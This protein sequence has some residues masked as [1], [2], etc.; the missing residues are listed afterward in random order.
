MD[1][2]I[3]AI[4]LRQLK[5]QYRQKY[6]KPNKPV[7]RNEDSEE[8]KDTNLANQSTRINIYKQVSESDGSLVS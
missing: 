2:T 7:A 8:M 1:K 6:K 4:H 5:L 3:E